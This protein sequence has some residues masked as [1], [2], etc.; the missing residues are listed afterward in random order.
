MVRRKCKHCNARITDPKIGLQCRRCQHYWRKYKIRVPDYNAL[1]E[2]QRNRCAICG[3]TSK[4]TASSAAR[5]CIDHCHTTGK[6]RG[7]LCVNC[8][9]GIGS[10]M[11][12]VN[13]F[14]K[15]LTYLSTN[16]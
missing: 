6:V 4:T 9:T 14:S 5:F 15:A 7:L 11:E 12:D 3:T 16:V 8:N 1:L 2:K 10:L 13:L